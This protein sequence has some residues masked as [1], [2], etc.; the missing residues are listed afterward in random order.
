ME[1]VFKTGSFIEVFLLKK[2]HL[3]S[4]WKLPAHVCPGGPFFYKII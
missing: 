1:K 4:L 3:M 2:T